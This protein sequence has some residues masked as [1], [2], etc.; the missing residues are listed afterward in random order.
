MDFWLGSHLPQHIWRCVVEVVSRY[1]CLG[2]HMSEESS[3][4]N[5]TFSLVRKAKQHLHVLRR[6]RPAGLG[7]WSITLP[8]RCVVEQMCGSI[9][10]APA[11][12]CD[13]GGAEKKTHIR[14]FALHKGIESACPQ[15]R[16]FTPPDARRKQLAPGWTSLNQHPQALPLSPQARGCRA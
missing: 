15:Q 4:S 7:S 11:P 8:C 6:L 13:M 1:R 16:T 9:Y 2:G 10:Y 12:L 5:I 3:W 14:W